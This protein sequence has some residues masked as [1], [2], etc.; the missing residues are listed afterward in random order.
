MNPDRIPRRFITTRAGVECVRSWTGI[1][2]IL[3]KHPHTVSRYP[4]PVR[5]EANGRVWIPAAELLAW[6]AKRGLV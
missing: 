3:G 4:I 2:L 1:A 6:A 5:R